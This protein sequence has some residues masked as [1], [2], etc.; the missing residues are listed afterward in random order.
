MRF[1]RIH[2]FVLSIALLFVVAC[3][4]TPPRV[5]GAT[6]GTTVTA[7][8]I[9]DPKT[10]FAPRDHMIQLVVD[11]E[12]VVTN[13]TVGVKWYAVGSSNRL[14][15]EGE[16]ALDA[17]NT[18]AEFALNSANDWQAGNYQVVIYLNGNPDRTLNFQV[19]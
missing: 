6:L 19:Q 12:N 8:K 5:T 16:A 14:L 3:G 18:S 2:W 10:T 1:F 15:F 9:A 4:N 13:T 17:F 7:G 11:V